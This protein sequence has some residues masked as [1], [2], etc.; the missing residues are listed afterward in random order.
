MTLLMLLQDAQQDPRD[1]PNIWN[2]RIPQGSFDG[3]INTLI[4]LDTENP[5][6]GP[7]NFGNPA[8]KLA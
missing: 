3:Y 8:K 6:K 5:D 4:I 1:C 2:F 7:I